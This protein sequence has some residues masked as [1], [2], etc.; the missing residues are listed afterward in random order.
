MADVA[1]AAGVSIATV[2]RAL[3]NVPGVSDRTRE[4]IQQIA[5]ELS[6]VVS[7]EASALSRG[8]TGR[9]AIVMPRLDA[10]FYSAMIASMA[11]VLRA[12][13]FD[14]LVYQVEAERERTRFL[15]ELPARRKVDAVI[16]TALPMRQSE[17]DRLELLGVHVVIAGGRVRDYPYVEVDD[18]EVGRMAVQHLL[19]LGHTAIA[20]IRTSDA[21]GAAWSSDHQRVR[22]WRDTLT[23]A[24]FPPP[25]S[26]WRQ[27][28][29]SPGPAAP[30]CS[31]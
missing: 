19:D 5:R 24:G 15:R 27:S 17:V 14:M 25:R 10:W 29:T 4:R 6:Y 13:D 16:L 23:S 20:M 1:S 31:S 8:Q 18:V 9:V 3:R 11:P 28:R 7:P 12:A 30:R 21:E 26:T 2:S 22:G